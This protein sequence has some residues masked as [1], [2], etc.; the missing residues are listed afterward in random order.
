MKTAKKFV[1]RWFD[2]SWRGR[3]AELVIIP[4]IAK[5]ARVDPTTVNGWVRRYDHFPKPVKEALAGPGPTRYFVL[6]DVID[7]LVTYREDT[8]AEY[9]DELDRDIAAAEATLARLTALR[10][11]LQSATT[12]SGE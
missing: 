5:M 11:R 8:L 9:A 2:E 7:W 6:A 12:A 4:E 1:T 3:D 10:D